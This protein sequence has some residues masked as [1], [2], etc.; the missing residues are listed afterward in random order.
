MRKMYTRHSHRAHSTE[1]M[2]CALEFLRLSTLLLGHIFEWFRV[3]N[4]LIFGKNDATTCTF[5][6]MHSTQQ[7]ATVKLHNICNRVIF[8][9]LRMQRKNQ[10]VV[11]AKFVVQTHFSRHVCER[12]SIYSVLAKKNNWSLFAC[13]K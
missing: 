3:N 13:R 4:W 1:G 9:M 10:R 7:T 8:Q 11:C 2:I 5:D 6:A 12:F